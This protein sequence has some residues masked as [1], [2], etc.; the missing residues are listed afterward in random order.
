MK[1]L[2]CKLCISIVLISSIFYGCK[3]EGDISNK[4]TESKSSLKFIYR[5]QIISCADF[6]SDNPDLVLF[7]VENNTVYVFDNNT[8]FFNW[9]NTTT[10]ANDVSKLE[11]QRQEILAFAEAN[12]VI[13][14]YNKTGE[15]KAEYLTYLEKYNQASSSNKSN[16]LTALYDKAGA[17][18]NSS[19]YVIITP[20]PYGTIG[21]MD[22]KA[23][24]ITGV[25]VVTV[26]Y[27]K[28]WFSGSRVYISSFGSTINF[29]DI[30]FDNK[31]SSVLSL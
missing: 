5:N 6:N 22:N 3:K 14:E 21:N 15:L 1:Q 10:Y 17:P 25:T 19:Y 24:S 30:S 11:S 23:S 27:D 29:S 13:E 8:S 16:L 2:V 4:T 9:V 20:W 26:C 31:T 18:S 12:G 28:T 7:V